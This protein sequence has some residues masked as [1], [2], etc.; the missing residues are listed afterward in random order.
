[1]KLCGDSV[2]LRQE[3]ISQTSFT[4]LYTL[5]FL[6]LLGR[7]RPH[8]FH[9]A[10]RSFNNVVEHDTMTGD[11]IELLDEQIERMKGGGTLSENEVKILCDRVSAFKT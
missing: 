2:V 9:R 10:R 5:S 4:E 3:T 8:S 11:S 7:S 1:V 6:P